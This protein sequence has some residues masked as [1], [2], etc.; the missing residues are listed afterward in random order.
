VE[1]NTFDKYGHIGI[2]IGNQNGAVIRNNTF[3]PRTDQT[4]EVFGVYGTGTVGGGVIE[5]NDYL[6]FRIGSGIFLNNVKG[7]NSSVFVRNNFLYM[8]DSSA[9]GVSRGILIQEANSSD[10]IAVNNSVAFHSD[11]AASGAITVIDGSGIQ[12]W[13]NNIGA[14]GTAPAV[15][16]EKLYSVTASDNNNYF[17]T[18]LMWRLGNVYTTLAN[19]Q[20]ATGTDAASVSVNPGFNGSDLHTCAPELNGAAESVPFVTD[21]FDGDP[22]STTPDIGADEFVGDAGGLLAEDAFLKCPSESVNLGNEP[23]AGVTYSWTPSGNTSEI[24]VTA[25]GTYVVTATSSCG[26]FSDTAVVTNKPLPVA[27]FSVSTVGLAAIFTNNSTGGTSYFWDFGDGGTSTEFSPSHVYSSAATYSATLTVTNECGSQTFGPLP[28]NV[29]NA[30][31]EENAAVSISLFPNPTSGMFTLSLGTSVSEDMVVTIS[32][33]TGKVVLNGQIPSDT[34]QITLDASALSS[35][36]YSVKI[37]GGKF[38]R[39]LRLVRN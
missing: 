15:R 7:G 17:G 6:S 24:S 31:V 33:I 20:S 1:G 19:L 11:N 14:F 10:I 8:G 34:K 23:L 37:S 21:D 9:T 5:A 16:I 25:A 39:V 27:D 18:N 29:I 22:R 36:I 3:R 30:S 12:I 38:S 35:G 26:S 2:I 4:Q 13:N 32:D 28:V